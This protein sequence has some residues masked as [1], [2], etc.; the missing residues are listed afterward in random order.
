EGA[1][2]S[3]NVELSRWGEVPE[4]DFE[5]KDHVALGLALGILEFQRA[6]KLAGPRTYILKNA[7]A[8]LELAVLRF[9]LD[10]LIK[11]GFSPMIVPCLVKY[12]PLFGTAYFPGGEEQTYLCDRDRL[13]LAGTSEVPVTAYHS[14]EMLSGEELP[15]RYCGY[16]TCFRREAGAA[17]RDTKGLYRIHQ[18]NKVE[19]VIICRAD[20][21]ESLRQ[22]HFIR[23]NAEQILQELELP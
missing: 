15:L 11:K 8:L 7:G 18:F 23:D 12:E 16:S 9:A 17:G 6:S 2:E 13:Y 5:L 4:P 20:E 21:E 1:D 19:Q 10:H 14:G 3:E 22:H